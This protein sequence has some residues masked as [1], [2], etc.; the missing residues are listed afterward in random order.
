V[1]AAESAGWDFKPT[2]TEKAISLSKKADG[3]KVVTV[4]A[5]S[6]SDRK[7]G[8][9]WFSKTPGSERSHLPQNVRCSVD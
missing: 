6:G 1:A 5:L 4:E 9:C 8:R 3:T 7:K 2:E